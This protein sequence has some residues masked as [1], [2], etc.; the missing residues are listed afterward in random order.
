MTDNEARGTP[1][2]AFSIVKSKLERACKEINSMHK[3]ESYDQFN[4]VTLYVVLNRA[5]IK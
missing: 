5:Y 2:S 3:K 1:F 4:L